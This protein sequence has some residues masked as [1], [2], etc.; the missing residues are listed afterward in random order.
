MCLS[1]GMDSILTLSVVMLDSSE[2]NTAAGRMNVLVPGPGR[3]PKKCLVMGAL[4]WRE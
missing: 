3:M 1:D 4:T 2:V